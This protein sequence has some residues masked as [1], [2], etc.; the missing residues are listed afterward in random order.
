ML[1]LLSIMQGHMSLGLHFCDDPYCS[2]VMWYKDDSVLMLLGILHT[3]D[4]RHLC[5]LS[6]QDRGGRADALV[7]AILGMYWDES[8]DNPNSFA[9]GRL[10]YEP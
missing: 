4:S 3:L 6:D 9:V 8:T 5:C 10:C 7:I 1:S 2:K